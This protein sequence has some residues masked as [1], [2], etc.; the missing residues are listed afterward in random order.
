MGMRVFASSMISVMM[1]SGSSILMFCILICFQVKTNHVL[2]KRLV[3][4]MEF[5]V[6]QGVRWT[7]PFTDNVQFGII[8]GSNSNSID[9]VEVHVMGDSIRCYDSPGADRKKDRDNVLLKDCPPPFTDAYRDAYGSGFSDLYVI[10]DLDNPHS[11]DTSRFERISLSVVDGGKT[12]SK[13]MMKEIYNH[14]WPEQLEAEKV[15]GYERAGEAEEF[16]G[17]SGVEPDGLDGPGF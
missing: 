2:R 8:V 7:Y 17:L 4:Y 10:A 1:E 3:I 15:R 16:F 9:V 13:R 5:E 11:L 14:P 12:V 6:G